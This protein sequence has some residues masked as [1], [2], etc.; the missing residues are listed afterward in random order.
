MCHNTI[1]CLVLIRIHEIITSILLFYEVYVLSYVENSSL[2]SQKLC[3]VLDAKSHLSHQHALNQL[4]TAVLDS[5]HTMHKLEVLASSLL[6]TDLWAVLWTIMFMYLMWENSS[7][8][9]QK[10]CSVLV[11]KSHLS[12]Q[13]ALNQLKTAVLDS[14]HTMHE[15]D[16]EH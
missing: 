10:L 14:T 4:E 13:H 5:T 7:L 1:C 8:L 11:V 3:S 12:H 15:H 2:L 16:H 9:S 6:V